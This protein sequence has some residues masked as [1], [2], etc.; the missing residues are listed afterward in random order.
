M[1]NQIIPEEQLRDDFLSAM[2]RSDET[3]SAPKGFAESV[4]SRINI[5]PSLKTAPYKPPV[6]LTWGIPGVIVS[7]L[8]MLLLIGPA[9]ETAPKK[10][11]L[12][13]FNN[14]FNSI[15]TWLSGISLDVKMPDM[16]M[17]EN[18][19][20]MLIGGMVFFWGFWLL[21]RLLEKKHKAGH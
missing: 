8:L 4:M 1:A 7:C 17:P 2:I 14:L 9:D 16:A 10:I 13:V 19:V 3:T 20:R 21:S 15:S 6:W 5:L 11:D 12:S 18:T